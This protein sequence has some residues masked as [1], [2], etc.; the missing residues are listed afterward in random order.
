[1][2]KNIFRDYD[3]GA[4]DYHKDYNRESGKKP[5]LNDQEKGYIRDPAELEKSELAKELDRRLEERLEKI[6]SGELEPMSARQEV[7]EE[8]WPVEIYSPLLAQ[9]EDREI[10]CI[11][12]SDSESLEETFVRHQEEQKADTK[13]IFI[14]GMVGIGVAATIFLINSLTLND[15]FLLSSAAAFLGWVVLIYF[16][17]LR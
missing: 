12:T 17:P 4:G 3:K 11:N 6:A 9:A 1:M 15:K 8:E 10:D 5:S 16:K 14:A 2:F 7:K 13:F